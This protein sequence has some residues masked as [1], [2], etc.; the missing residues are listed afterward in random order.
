MIRYLIFKV[1]LVVQLC[2]IF[3]VVKL[4]NIMNIEKDKAMIE[5][6]SEFNNFL[7]INALFKNQEIHDCFG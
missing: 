7:E 1:R 2:F 3:L 4:V 5:F 6:S